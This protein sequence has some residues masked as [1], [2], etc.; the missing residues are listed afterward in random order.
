MSA[1]S[2]TVP[3]PQQSLFIDDQI[4]SSNNI[5]NNELPS[6]GGGSHTS[7]LSE[8]TNSKAHCALKPIYLGLDLLLGCVMGRFY[9]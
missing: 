5:S 4:N 1:K 7:H 8:L 3:A 2:P 9:L 6:V